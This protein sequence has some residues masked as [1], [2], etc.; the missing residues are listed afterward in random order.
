MSPQAGSILL[1]QIAPRLHSTIPHAVCCI[2]SEDAQELIQDGIAMAAKILTNA[3][4]KGKKVT[5]GNVAYYTLKHL[6][7]GRRSVGFSNADVL[8][9]ATQLNGRSTVTSIHEEVVLNTEVNGTVSVSELIS[10]DV[11]DPSTKAARKLDWQEFHASLDPKDQELIECM[12]EGCTAR[13]SRKHLRI[14]SGT[15]RNRIHRLRRSL[16]AFFGDSL[17]DEACRQP[18]WFND[19]RAVKEHSACHCARSWQ[20]H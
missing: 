14:S 19:L 8:G 20:T 11:E 15:A 12:A 18:Q 5:A 7:S 2:G 17:F 16:L 4:K 1:N 10:I 9:S 6:K 3:Q 13:E